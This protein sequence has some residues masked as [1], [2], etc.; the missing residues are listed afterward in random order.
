M[1]FIM[2]VV[3]FIYDSVNRKRWDNNKGIW[4]CNYIIY[5]GWNM[6]L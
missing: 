4:K 6:L 2:F 1:F 5:N 3:I